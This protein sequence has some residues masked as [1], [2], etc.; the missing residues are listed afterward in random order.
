[1]VTDSIYYLVC[2]T[3]HRLL[4]TVYVCEAFSNSNLKPE[5]ECNLASIEAFICLYY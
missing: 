2:I 4:Y 1:M 3:D 5:A